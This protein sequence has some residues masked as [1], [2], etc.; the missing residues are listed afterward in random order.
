MLL[1]NLYWHILQLSLIQVSKYS[2]QS[3]MLFYLPLKQKILKFYTN[4]KRLSYIFAS[5][6]SLT[7]LFDKTR[8]ENNYFWD[9]SCKV[10][11]TNE[12]HYLVT[13]RFGV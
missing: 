13:R 5:Y 8:N 2:L 3:Q 7:I 9:S 1:I 10:L 6:C 4:N 12:I 11:V